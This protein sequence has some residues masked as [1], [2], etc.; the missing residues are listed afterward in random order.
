MDQPS[1]QYSIRSADTLETEGSVA[2]TDA[3]GTPQ[4]SVSR[5]TKHGHQVLGR[6]SRTGAGTNSNS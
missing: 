1:R 5:V 2:G 3:W 6:C 4:C